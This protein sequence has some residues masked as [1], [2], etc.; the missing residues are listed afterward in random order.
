[1]KSLSC[2]KYFQHREYL[3]KC[4]FCLSTY[5]VWYLFDEA[6][7][8]MSVF[9]RKECEGQLAVQNQKERS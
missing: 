6:C 5:V 3:T 1:M 9:A 2:F 8:S 7:N 4:S